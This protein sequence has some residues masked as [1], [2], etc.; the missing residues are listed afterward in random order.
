MVCG[1]GAVTVTDLVRA[2]KLPVT[3]HSLAAW[4]RGSGP[5]VAAGGE[6]ESGEL[7]AGSRWRAWLDPPPGDCYGATLPLRIELRWDEEAGV[8]RGPRLS[9][10]AALLD[11]P[12]LVAYRMSGCDWTILPVHADSHHH[13]IINASC[14]SR[15]LHHD[16]VAGRR[17]LAVQLF[18]GLR[19][20][21]ISRMMVVPAR[22][23]RPPPPE[24]RA[25]PALPPTGSSQEEEEDAAVASRVLDALLAHDRGQE[26]VSSFAD[27]Y[28]GFEG[29]DTMHGVALPLRFFHD[30]D[31]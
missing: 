16:D 24:L 8:G 3:P 18:E 10:V 19:H 23:C 11:G 31:R 2:A 27:V 28:A 9:D 20:S 1:T 26:V 30:T 4:Q 12:V 25:T 7:M 5:L 22:Q 14:A 13:L 6:Q 15:P 29:R 17:L 21:P